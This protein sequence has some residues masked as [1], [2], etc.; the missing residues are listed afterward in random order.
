MIYTV[1]YSDAAKR[2]ID[3]I[4]E[5]IA[6][7]LLAPKTAKKQVNRIIKI[8]DSLEKLPYRFSLYNEE[9]WFNNGLRCTTVDNYMVFYYPIDKTG[10][11]QVLRIIYGGRD[12][13][14]ELSK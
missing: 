5:Y 14:T 2:D 12:I 7:K 13:K 3:K 10:I 8:I 11:V 1:I 4:Y 9:P 6:Y